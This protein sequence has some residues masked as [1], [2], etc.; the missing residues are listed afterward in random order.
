MKFKILGFLLVAV[1]GLGGYYY[2][3]QMRI[4]SKYAEGSCFSDKNLGV[5]FKV[6]NVSEEAYELVVVDSGHYESSPE[7]QKGSEL[8]FSKPAVESGQQYHHA[9]CESKKSATE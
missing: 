3:T 8:L 5:K 9:F 1:L 6:K 4:K 7:F 2:F